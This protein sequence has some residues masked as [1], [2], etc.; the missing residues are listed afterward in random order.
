M[1]SKDFAKKKLSFCDFELPHWTDIRCHR[2]LA[3]APSDS[4]L[5][6]PQLHIN[7]SYRS[8][9]GASATTTGPTTP[10]K[11]VTERLKEP[12]S[13]T[14]QTK[15]PSTCSFSHSLITNYLYFSTSNCPMAFIMARYF[16]LSSKRLVKESVFST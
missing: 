9:R 13:A 3:L 11:S 10:S 14:I 8:L 2:L 1:F 16:S 7:K 12:R 5:K 6:N 15:S 4:M